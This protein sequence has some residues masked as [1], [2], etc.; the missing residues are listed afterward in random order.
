MCFACPA[1]CENHSSSFG[2]FILGSG[3]ETDEHHRLWLRD[4]DVVTFARQHWYS[5]GCGSQ[6]IGPPCFKRTWMPGLAAPCLCSLRA[7]PF[8]T[9]WQFI[10]TPRS[11]STISE[12]IRNGVRSFFWIT[13]ALS[14][15]LATPRLRI[16][17]RRTCDCKITD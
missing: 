12:Q 9:P 15:T 1:R 7:L 16:A 13:F 6:T 8:T 14:V 5:N 17:D 4:I 3:N 2:F 11:C 10:R